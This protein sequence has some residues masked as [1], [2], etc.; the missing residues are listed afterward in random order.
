[1][2]TK[3]MPVHVPADLHADTVDLVARF[4]AALAEKL[5]KAEKKYGYS[6]R[7]SED[8]WQRECAEK[9]IE[10]VTK[11]DPRDVAAYCAFMWHHGWRTSLQITAYA[12]PKE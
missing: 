8:D 7:W 1:M 2:K 11:G 10:H 5:H 12:E 9:L 3:T 4:A 6:N